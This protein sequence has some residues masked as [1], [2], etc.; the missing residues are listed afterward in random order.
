MPRVWGWLLHQNA[1]GNFCQETAMKPASEGAYWA[2]AN[3]SQGILCRFVFPLFGL[4]F[5]GGPPAQGW[6][7]EYFLGLCFHFLGCYSWADPR[8]KVEIQNMFWVCV[9]TFWAV[10]LGRTPG[11]RLKFR[12]CFGFVFPLFGLLF[13]GGPPAQGWNSEYVLGLCFHF[14][15][16]YSWADPGPRLKFR[17]LKLTLGW[18]PPGINKPSQNPG[19]I[20]THYLYAHTHIDRRTN[21]HTDI[22]TYI[23]TY[24]HTCIHA[25]MHTCIHAYMHICLYLHV[26]VYVYGYVW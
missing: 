17:W 26:Y 21:F 16:C 24:I 13:L 12:I 8:P 18:I 20:P 23:H 22:H 4:F 15:G 6:N 5:L 11:P 7:S 25:Y 19:R 10:I 14:L 1:V 2:E 3:P 9:S